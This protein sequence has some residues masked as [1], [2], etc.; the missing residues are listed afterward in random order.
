LTSGARTPAAVVE[1]ISEAISE[2][3]RAPDVKER[4]ERASLVTIGN[5][6]ARAAAFIAGERARWR[7]I[8]EAQRDQAKN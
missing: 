4:L 1:A 7:A 8:V 3:L 5:T 2:A 6:S